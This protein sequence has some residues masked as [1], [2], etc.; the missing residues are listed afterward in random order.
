[1]AQYKK[2]LSSNNPS[3]QLAD[4]PK[5]GRPGKIQGNR[6]LIPHESD[7]L[8]YEISGE[9]VWMLALVHTARHQWP[10]VRD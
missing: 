5:L 3:F 2:A 6:E 1:M 4:H 7:R 9:T 8:A 10:L